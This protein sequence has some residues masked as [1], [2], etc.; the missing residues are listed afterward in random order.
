MQLMGKLAVAISGLL[1][2]P[3]VAMAQTGP[4]PPQLLDK[5]RSLQ[6]NMIRACVDDAS[7]GGQLDRAIAQAIGDAL[8]LEVK[9]V[10]ALRGFPING[11]GYLAEMQV[12]LNNDCDLLMG[13]AVQPNSPFPDWALVTRPY[14]RIPF[15]LATTEP[16]FERLADIPKDR[17]IGTAVASLGELVFITTM[18]QRP[19]D[20]RWRRLPYADFKLMLQRMREGRLAAMLLWQPALA[21]LLADDPE[22]ETV[23]LIATD[24]VPLA[25]VRVGAL[26][27]VR[28][29]YLRSQVD[30]AI[31][32]LVEDGTIDQILEDLGLEGTAG[33]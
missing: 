19:E 24:P 26:I 12:H 3:M 15:V 25:E 17:F 6:G 7:A 16:D 4:V 33:G 23:R 13:I 27:N 2:L 28:N 9:F 8:F 1:F 31:A 14:A 22:A 30:A 21:Q 18:T 5:S 29:D 32:E 11:E 20:Q 10:P